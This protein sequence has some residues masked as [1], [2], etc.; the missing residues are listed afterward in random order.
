[1]I[2]FETERLIV[3]HL[4]ETDAGNFFLL[5]GNRQVMQFIH[6]V[7]SREESDA[8]LTKVMA[9][10]S[11]P[12]MGAWAIEEKGSGKFS[13]SFVI[14]PIPGDSE[15]TQLGYMFMPEFWG[16]GYATEI[17]R[18]GINYFL[19]STPLNE[20]YGVV[21]EG[22][23]PSQRVLLKTGFQPYDTFDEGNKKILRFVLYK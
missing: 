10:Y 23:N 14:N 6:P 22:N 21:E 11:E 8:F 15:K 12:W 20:I 17:V 19:N 1:M 9:G 13:G 5:Q 7:R 18:G 4:K 16:L 2:V 3:R